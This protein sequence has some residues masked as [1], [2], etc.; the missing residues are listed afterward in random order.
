MNERLA[1][2]QGH[3]GLRR[4]IVARAGPG[5]GPEIHPKRSL[6]SAPICRLSDQAL[7]DRYGKL[8]KG[9]TCA[10][11]RPWTT[12]FCS[13]CELPHMYPLIRYAYVPS[14]VDQRIPV[15]CHDEERRGKA[16]GGSD[17]PAER[18]RRIATRGVF[19]QAFNNRKELR[20][21]N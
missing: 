6:V 20:R 15:A 17:A 1:L 2:D 14:V 13:E 4:H 7:Y 18:C 3:A 16:K 19:H 10:P 9:R 12:K 21:C 5:E 11:R 8:Q